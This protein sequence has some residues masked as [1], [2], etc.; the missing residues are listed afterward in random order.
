MAATRPAEKPPPGRLWP[1]RKR[2]RATDSISGSS[3]GTTSSRRNGP[4]VGW[5]GCR[6]RRGPGGCQPARAL[7]TSRPA[8]ASTTISPSVSRARKSTMMTFTALVPAAPGTAFSR[9]QSGDRPAR[10]RQHGPGQRRHAEARGS[11]QDPVP[12]PA[13]GGIRRRARGGQ[14]VQ[15]EQQQD[16]GHDL[17]QQLGQGQVRGREAGERERDH[18]PDDADQDEGRQPVPVARHEHGAGG[19]GEE[20]DHPAGQ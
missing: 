8:T 5:R 15:R 2:N 3:S 11:G 16:D 4:A 13:S 19:D 20:P 7:P 10:A 14:E 9:Y 17:H 6:L 1:R 18:E 12:P